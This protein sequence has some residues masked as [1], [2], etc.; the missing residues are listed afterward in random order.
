[1]MILPMH[2]SWPMAGPLIPPSTTMKPLGE[3]FLES[4]LT[5]V[6]IKPDTA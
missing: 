1:M 5:H 3:S 4:L 6:Q 2:F